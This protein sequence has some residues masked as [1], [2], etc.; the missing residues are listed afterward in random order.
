[1]NDMNSVF[2][3]LLQRGAPSN[4]Q[5]VAAL[6]AEC[7]PKIG[8]A[9]V[10]KA[11][12]FSNGLIRLMLTQDEA[13]ALAEKLQASGLPAM[14]VPVSAIIQPPQAFTLMRVEF[15]D[16]ALQI[17]V[18]AS[19]A[20][21]SV[22]WEA[23]R[24]LHVC[25]VKVKAA[26]LH[27]TL[28]TESVTDTGVLALTAAAAISGVSPMAIY[29]A[30]KHHIDAAEKSA[31]ASVSDSGGGGETEV[32]L[33]ILM[34]EPLVRLRIRQNKFSYDFLGD[35]R[36]PVSRANFALLLAE[37][38]ARAT[39]A[40]TTGLFPLALAGR[41]IEPE[42]FSVDEGENDQHLAA[43]LTCEASMGLPRG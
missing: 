42:K 38:K 10:T 17:L 29:A 7:A 16:A 18:G 13:Q 2:H 5:A 36:Q 14:P 28:N 35:R 41:R 3:V 11:C 12:R 15:T 4:W 40:A 8:R 1:M 31:K 34:M 21:Q 39:Q 25:C 43:L 32:L 6:A 37:V 33:E 23:I 26:P 20:A 9:L 27:T 19:T 24:L 30:T 22:P